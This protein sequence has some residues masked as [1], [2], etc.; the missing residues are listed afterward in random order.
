MDLNATY[1]QTTNAQSLDKGE[2]LIALVS[3]CLQV[4]AAC[5]CSATTLG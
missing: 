1:S 2:A 4:V 5:H 3:I